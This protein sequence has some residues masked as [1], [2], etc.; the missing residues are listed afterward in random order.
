[1]N[2]TVETRSST[3]QFDVATDVLSRGVRLITLAMGG[4]N[5][6]LTDGDF[7]KIKQE[8]IQKVLG[9]LASK[10][11]AEDEI[12]KGFRDL[13]T[14]IGFSNR[15]FPAA[16]ES[17]LEYVF[18]NHDLPRI[19]LLVD[20]YNLVSVETSLSLGAHDL[21]YVSGNV[22][23]RTTTGAEGFRP[24]GAAE[25]KAVRPGGYAYIDDDHDVICLLEV[26]QVEKTKVTQDT[27]EC[28]FIIQGNVAS[29]YACIRTA[30]ERL[31]DLTTR[32][33]G[34]KVRYLYVGEAA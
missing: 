21:A 5:N 14:A 32:F 9:K 1:M 28:F 23:L 6:R 3:I 2:L 33:C 4:L 19:N 16:S 10:P 31:V 22:H 18:K 30:A 12:L 26:K 27:K 25:N 29:D 15:N 24:L 34:G 7:E 11:M 17:L 13:H 8:S 20:I